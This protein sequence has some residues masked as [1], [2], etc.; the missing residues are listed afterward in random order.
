MPGDKHPAFDAEH[1]GHS[2]LIE[3]ESELRSWQPTLEPVESQSGNLQTNATVLPSEATVASPTSV[4]ETPSSAGNT[5]E[6]GHL[7]QA[8]EPEAEKAEPVAA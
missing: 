6:G 7:A 4:T 2:I 1:K 5:N 8:V 3:A